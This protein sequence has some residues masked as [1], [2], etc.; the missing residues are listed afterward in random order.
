MKQ[1]R[2]LLSICTI[3]FH[4][5]EINSQSIFNPV[6]SPA[7]TGIGG[8]SV[9]L[10]I[11]EAFPANASSLSSINNSTLSLN[12]ES[13]FA[14]SGIAG[15]SVFAGIKLGQYNGLGLG[16]LYY[17]L[18]E[19]NQWNLFAGYGMQ[20]SNKLSMGTSGGLLHFNNPS[21]D[22]TTFGMIS[23]GLQYKL[24]TN[25]LL[26]VSYQRLL[27]NPSG[28]GKTTGDDLLIG[29]K[30]TVSPLVSVFTEVEKDH[31]S[32]PNLKIGIEY[33]MLPTFSFRTGITSFPQSF[34]T[35]IGMSLSPFI[36][37]DTAFSFYQ[38]IGFTPAIGIKIQLNKTRE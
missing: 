20:L 9:A 7:Q 24:F 29:A 37:I 32:K 28:L 33:Q 25:L 1:I 17:G 30:Y 22:I 5:Y 3:Y 26:G 4:F 6:K 38:S 12:G 11:A 14:G 27:S 15:T 8:Q 35:G 16:A 13:R 18:P 10:N 2:G 23:F 34:S 21:G 31:F 19:Y 36:H